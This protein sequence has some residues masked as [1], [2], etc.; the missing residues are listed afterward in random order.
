[1]H[2]D[3]SGRSIVQKLITASVGTSCY[4]WTVSNRGLT[5]T[6]T[7]PSGHDSRCR[8]ITLTHNTPICFRD[9][10]LARLITFMHDHPIKEVA[11]ADNRCVVYRH[12]TE[13][14]TLY[15]SM[16]TDEDVS[17]I[18]LNKK[19]QHEFRNDLVA[20]V[21]NNNTGRGVAEVINSLEPDKVSV[22][23]YVLEDATDDDFWITSIHIK[24]DG[25]MKVDKSTA[26]KLLS[27]GDMSCILLPD[28]DS[29]YISEHNRQIPPHSCFATCKFGCSSCKYADDMEGDIMNAVIIG[30]KIPENTLLARKHISDVLLST[31]RNSGII[32][33][34][35][36]AEIAKLSI[37][38]KPNTSIWERMAY[39]KDTSFF[40]NL[41][42][43]WMY[44]SRDV[45]EEGDKFFNISFSFSD[46]K[47]DSMHYDNKID[48]VVNLIL[49]F[50]DTVNDY[51]DM[52]DLQRSL[53]VQFED[54][55][56]V[57]IAATA[58]NVANCNTIRMFGAPCVTRDKIAYLVRELAD[59]G[60]KLKVT[61]HLIETKHCL[62]PNRIIL[63]QDCDTDWVI[64]KSYLHCLADAVML[65]FN[66]NK[67]GD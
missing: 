18:T 63:S 4:G 28:P 43:S 24:I 38:D 34:S 55:G 35:R 23:L 10:Y 15:L 29:K 48:S 12:E 19:K 62:V 54:E 41:E 39:Y 49:M 51:C 32:I 46:L 59:I 7:D 1:M 50:M 53:M 66:T 47:R 61:I 57:T 14:N 58:Y 64:R 3:Y 31:P 56:D 20:F 22:L 27:K 16:A 26:L 13:S 40:N 37:V 42:A 8:E 44:S 25:G 2:D 65:K 45:N 21:M 5:A 52:S 60:Y 33:N 17:K 9:G 11:K 67:E 6:W 36:L 30:S